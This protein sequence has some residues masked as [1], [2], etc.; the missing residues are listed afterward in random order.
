MLPKEKLLASLV[1]GREKAGFKE[2]DQFFF[3]IC[4]LLLY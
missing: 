2:Q 1:Q 3:T 4:S